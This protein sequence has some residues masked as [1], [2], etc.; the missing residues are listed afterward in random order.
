MDR[1]LSSASDVIKSR[2]INSGQ[3]SVRLLTINLFMRPV[4]NTNGTDYKEARLQA[5]TEKYLS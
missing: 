1:E 3:V 2:T 5:F 4:V